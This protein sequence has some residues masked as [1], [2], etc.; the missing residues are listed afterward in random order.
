[1]YGREGNVLCSQ[2]FFKNGVLAMESELEMERVYNDGKVIK[3]I[4]AKK[5]K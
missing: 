5:K 2:H 1:M 3:Y 4:V